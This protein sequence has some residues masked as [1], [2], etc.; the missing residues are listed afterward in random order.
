MSQD[1]AQWRQQVDA[2]LVGPAATPPPGVTSNFT[3]GPSRHKY[4]IVC[5]TICLTT[6]TTLVV[7][8]VYTKSRVL[9]SLGWDD[10]TSVLAWLGLIAFGVLIAIS[11]EYGAGKHMWD[12][13]G[14]DYLTFNKLTYAF[15]ITYTFDIL[16]TKASILLLYLRVF[17]LT[18]SLRI[19]IQIFL[20]AH[21]LFYIASFF[22]AVFMCF[23]LD[24]IWN[25]YVRHIKCLD[26]GALKV[27]SAVIN[28]VSDFAI[29]FIPISTVWNLKMQRKNKVRTM[30]IFATGLFGCIA[31]LVRVIF[32]TKEL[33]DKSYAQDPTWMSYPAILWSYAE[34]AAGI[35]CGCMPAVPAFCRHV[36]EYAVKISNKRARIEDDLRR[37]FR[38]DV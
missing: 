14:A 24:A 30:A 34:I 12:I 27:V 21:I 33:T 11:D 22:A 23:P 17:S 15:Y 26:I 13:T 9:K 38:S 7:I 2:R 5:Q 6:V 16:F 28:V 32:L 3:N 18:R 19:V 10:A 8:R 37:M 31:G 4:N 1:D 25:P 36:R 35:L 20:W 29:L